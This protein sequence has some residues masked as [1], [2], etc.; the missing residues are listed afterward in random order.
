MDAAISIAVLHHISSVS[1]RLQLLA[2]LTRIL[3]P[4]GQALVTVWASEQEDT[5]KLA[6]WE[7][8]PASGQP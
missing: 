1:R 7:P 4:G 8:I 5:K 6:K 2:E 3:R